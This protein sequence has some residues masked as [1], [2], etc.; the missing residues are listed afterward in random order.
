[1]G[2]ANREWFERCW[3]FGRQW[4]RFWR[5]AIEHAIWYFGKRAGALQTELVA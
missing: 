1:M 5:P 3:D 2:A 4:T